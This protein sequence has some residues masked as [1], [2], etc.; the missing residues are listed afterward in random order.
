MRSVIWSVL[1]AAATLPICSAAQATFSVEVTTIQGGEETKDADPNLR[2]ATCAETYYVDGYISKTATSPGPAHPPAMYR[3]LDS[4]GPQP[5]IPYDYGLAADKLHAAYQFTVHVPMNTT[6]D[7]WAQLELI[8]PEQR[9]SNR[10]HFI[11]HCRARPPLL[12]V[13]PGHF[14]H[15]D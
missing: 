10:V 1:L 14:P 15:G 5:P 6:A 8:S 3:W 12:P 13:A 11:L 7:V 2:N 9:F 4:N